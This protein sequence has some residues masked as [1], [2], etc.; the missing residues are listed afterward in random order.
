VV[1]FAPFEFRG[2]SA[3]RLVASYGWRYSFATQRISRAEPIP[4]FL[5]PVRERAAAFA[6][7]DP[8]E[9]PHALVTHYPAGTQIGW[10]RDRAAFGTVIGLSLVSPCTLRFRRRDGARWERAAL[11]VAPRSA[12]LLQ[13]LARDT[14]E[15]SIPPVAGT[16][17]SV[18]FRSLRYPT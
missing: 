15:H 6:G 2:Y 16:R 7:L 14:W 9:L 10:H 17:Y 1:P 12:Y 18:T 11:A 5:L 4:Y 8:E 3:N 13:G